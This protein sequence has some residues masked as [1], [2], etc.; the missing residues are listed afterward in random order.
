MKELLTYCL[1]LLGLTSSLALAE[2]TPW[3][4]LSTEQHSALSPLEQEWDKLP[5]S[6]QHHLLKIA[7]GY[8]SLSAEEKTRFH[9]S[10][11][12]WSKL[13]HEQRE[14]ARAKYKAFQKVPEEQRLEVKK[15]VKQGQENKPAQPTP[16]P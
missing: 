15:M 6:Q 11:P 10:L 2:A 16:Q 7:K 8:A 14:A 4:S 13:T 9:N 12:A 3:R 5:E 1:L